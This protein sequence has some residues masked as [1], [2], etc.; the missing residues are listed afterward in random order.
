MN[1]HEAQNTRAAATRREPAAACRAAVTPICRSA[2]SIAPD[3]HI[4]AILP[5][6]DERGRGV[7][8]YTA[9][10]G[11]HVSH[12]RVRT[13]LTRLAE[14][15]CCSLPLLRRRMRTLFDGRQELP[16][17]ISPH[18]ILVPCKVLVPRVAGDETVGY[19]SFAHIRALHCSARRP[20]RRSP[21]PAP[22]KGAPR[23]AT[24]TSPATGTPPATASR[25]DRD[26]PSYELTGG[27]T[28]PLLCA[29]T[30]A[31]HRLEMA[32]YARCRMFE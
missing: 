18:L 14:R 7:S 6:Y 10:G 22:G 32:A 3:A 31:R 28:I 24:S 9:D 2:F 15:R 13:I 8:I 30:T 1:N 20:H 4:A 25:P 11:R 21:V 5:V 16:L 29:S 27:L 23:G 19:F 12:L 17:P 26:L